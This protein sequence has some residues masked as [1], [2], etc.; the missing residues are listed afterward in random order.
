MD[1]KPA[2]EELEQSIKELE[3]EAVKHSRIEEALM[4]S[5]ER[6][7]TILDE[8]DLAYFEVDLEGNYTFVNDRQCSVF[9]YTKEEM[10]GMNYRVITPEEERKI[11][12]EAFAHAFLTG[13]P[14][15]RISYK[16]AAKDQPAGFTEVSAVPIRNKEGEIIGFRGIGQDVSERMQMEESIRQHAAELEQKSQEL[17]EANARMK[18]QTEKL[19]RVNKLFLDRELKMKELKEEIK[20]LKSMMQ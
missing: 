18:I 9:G 19:E 4:Q 11:P 7:R 10:I 6:Y 13:E 2:Y 5:E 12:D 15:K 1:K 8:L 16:M 3:E 17:A 14:V 20:E